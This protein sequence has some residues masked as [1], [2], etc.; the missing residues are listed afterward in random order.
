MFHGRYIASMEQTQP[1]RLSS[2]ARREHAA[3]F[4]RWLH[5]R[6]TERHYNLSSSRGG[7][8]KKLADETG[9]S[10]ATISRLL[11]GRALNPDPDSLRR[12]ADQLALP[13]GDVLV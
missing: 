9:L 6:M 1:S 4:G 12:I 10:Q 11:S 5:D 7:G 13:F 8:Q 2:T 3:A